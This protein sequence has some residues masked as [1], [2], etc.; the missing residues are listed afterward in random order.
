ME[1]RLA[2]MLR[3]K[4]EAILNEWLQ[5]IVNSYPGKAALFM[6]QEQN[7][8]TNPISYAFREAIKSI[9]SAIAEEK[10]ADRDKL[11]Y[12][13][14]IKATQGSDPLEGIA[15]ISIL[16]DL[17][18]EERGGSSADAEL[19]ILESRIDKISQSAE[20]MFIANRAKIAELAGSPV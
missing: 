6:R 20:K 7:R 9:Y 4:Q 11:D 2:E 16:K 15:F 17:L 19:D 12:A 3:R 10:E 14:K 13:I 18:R 5:R 8:F 1:E